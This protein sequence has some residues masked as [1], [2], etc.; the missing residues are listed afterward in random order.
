MNIF[1][2]TIDTLDFTTHIKIIIQD[3]TSEFYYP[4]LIEKLK[5]NPNKFTVGDCFFYYYGR[6]F[7]KGYKSIS[8]LSNPERPSF[9]KAVMKRDSKKIIALGEKI[10]NRNPVDLNVLLHVC[11]SL[12]EKGNADTTYYYKQRYMNLLEAIISTGDGKS[13]MT[14]IKIAD[15]EDDYIIKGVLGFFGGKETVKIDNHHAFS[16]WEK[17]GQYLYFEDILG[18]IKNV[19]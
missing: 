8:F 14:A 4:K 11:I 3:T 17:D 5:N 9:D 10:L 13:L 1:S 7:Q 18:E 12:K 19:Y 6:I 16:V 2:Q 15:L